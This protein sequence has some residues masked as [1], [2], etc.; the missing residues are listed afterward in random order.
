MNAPAYIRNHP[1]FDA[2][3]YAYLRAKGWS[4]RQIA[5]RWFEEAE[6]G[7]GPCGWSGHWVSTKLA[8]VTA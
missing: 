6:Q 8:A 1:N 2:N 7:K 5:A 3:D 4:N